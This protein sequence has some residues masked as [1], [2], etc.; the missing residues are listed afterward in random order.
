MKRIE[1]VSTLCGNY[2]PEKV[3]INLTKG[4]IMI[5]G[6]EVSGNDLLVISLNGNKER[7]LA[8]VVSPKLS[9]PKNDESISAILDLKKNFVMLIQNNKPKLIVLC[10]AGNDSK[11]K[12][13]RIEFAILCAC[14]KNNIKYETYASSAASKLIN[15]GF[16]KTEK[17]PFDDFNGKLGIPQKYKKAFI[18]AWRYFG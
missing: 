17:T 11:K 16:E 6:I 1:K 9:L 5:Y 15:S 2:K 10:E 3:L 18:T 14:E 8:E 7:Y 13:F 12:R 4:D